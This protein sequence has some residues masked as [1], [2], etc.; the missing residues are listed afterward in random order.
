M[1]SL[2]ELVSKCWD[3]DLSIDINPHP[4]GSIT[5]WDFSSKFDGRENSNHRITEGNL[6]NWKQESAEGALN[7]MHQEVD[8]YLNRISVPF[9]DD[10]ETEHAQSAL[11]EQERKGSI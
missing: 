9:M 8:A 4:F 6:K 3:N 2:N 10:H 1:K 7:R 5:I 11:T